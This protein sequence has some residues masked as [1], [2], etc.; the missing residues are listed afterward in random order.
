MSSFSVSIGSQLFGERCSQRMP[1][2]IC[3]NFENRV[4]KRAA[5]LLQFAYLFTSYKFEQSRICSCNSVFCFR[6]I[7]FVTAA[8]KPKPSRG[9]NRKPSDFKPHKEKPR[10]LPVIHSTQCYV[11]S[12]IEKAAVAFFAVAVNLQRRRRTRVCSRRLRF[13]KPFGHR[14][15]WLTSPSLRSLQLYSRRLSGIMVDVVS[16]GA[17]GRG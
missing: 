16:F 15:S 7:R 13:L 6:T 5:P 17:L 8:A 11:V 14:R 2:R 12:A 4:K 1:P 10:A 3:F 9:S